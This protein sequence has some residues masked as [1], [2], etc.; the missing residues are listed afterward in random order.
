MANDRRKRTNGDGRHFPVGWTEAFSEKIGRVGTMAASWIS[1]TSKTQ[2]A[3]RKHGRCSRLSI[4][5]GR[6][7]WTPRAIFVGADRG[8][9]R[10]SGV[11]RRICV[12]RPA[13]ASFLSRTLLRDRRPAC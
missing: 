1:R 4:P 9:A 6:Y 8:E 13:E 10:L 12:I 7:D 2:P 3:S 11:R 5:D